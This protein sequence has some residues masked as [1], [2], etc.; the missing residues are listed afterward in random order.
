M[1][2][3]IIRR[4]DSSGVLGRWRA[5]AGSIVVETNDPTL[6]S[7]SDQIL[8]T[9]QPIP[10]H[11][12]ERREFATHGDSLTEAPSTIKYLALFALELEQRGFVLEPDEG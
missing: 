10:I 2:T 7:A 8:R 5:D 3:G 11:G 12:A 6:R 1:Q 9:P 4:Q